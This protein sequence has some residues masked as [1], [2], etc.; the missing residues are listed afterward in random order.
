MERRV[1]PEDGVV[2]GVNGDDCVEFGGNDEVLPEAVLDF[3]LR[4]HLEFPD[5]GAVDVAQ[6]AD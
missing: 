5:G 6:M 2:F 4:G 1:L 3:L